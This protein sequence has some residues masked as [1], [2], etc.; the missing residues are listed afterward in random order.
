MLFGAIGAI[1]ALSFIVGAGDLPDLSDGWQFKLGDDPSWSAASFDESDWA[2]IRVGEAWEYQ[3]HADYDGYAWYRKRF[4]VPGELRDKNPQDESGHSILVVLGK[5]DDVD[6]V[7]F[8]GTLIGSTGAFPDAYESD[9]VTSRKYLLA[10]DLIRWDDENVLAVRVYDADGDGG[11]YE[12][13]YKLRL[14][15]SG[16]YLKVSFG[17]GRGDGVFE[18]PGAM[19]LTAR[20]NNKGGKEIAGQIKWT[21]EDDEK[22]VLAESIQDVAIETNP[23]DVSHDFDPPAPGIYRVTVALSND[24]GGAVGE[25]SKFLAYEPETIESPLTKEPDFDAF[26]DETLAELSA[27]DPE[28]SLSPVETYKSSSHKLYEVEMRSL[29]GVRVRGWY[30]R[31][32]GDGP[33][34]ALMRVPGYG[35]NMRPTRMTDP[36]AVLSFNVRGHGNS[37]QDVSGRPNNFWIRGLD[38]EDGY[39]YQGSYAD[40]VRGIDFLVSR[41]EV[42]PDRI[43][44]TGGS[45]GGGFSWATAALDPRVDFCAP[46][47]PFLC[48]WVKYFKASHWPEIDNWIAEKPSRSWAK[49]LRTLGYFDTLNMA[50][51]ITCPVFVGF[52][53]QDTTCPAATVFSVYNRLPGEKSYRLYPHAEHF[54]GAGHVDLQHQW[55]L[56]QFGIDQ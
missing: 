18:G 2:P 3:G 14:A 20:L 41:A 21:V 55:L 5:I 1:A 27:V 12:G 19:P 31:P 49:T 28:F 43:A 48:D 34:P 54:V 32:M 13:P 8:N 42:D 35:E 4:T 25:W 22:A 11:M 39:Y 53:L 23:V 44:V 30:E 29:D 47:I 7:F 24:D 56:K 37:Q 6:Q 40:C 26:W 10:D 50:S 46:D 16:D 33:F 52:S 36:I 9:W 38:D 45:Q 15:K 17:L 51:R